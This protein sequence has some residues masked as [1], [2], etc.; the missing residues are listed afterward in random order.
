MPYWKSVGL[1]WKPI[2]WPSLH[3]CACFAL[4]TVRRRSSCNLVGVL[5]APPTESHDLSEVYVNAWRVGELGA[6]KLVR[7]RLRFED[8]THGEKIRIRHGRRRNFHR[9]LDT[10]QHKASQNRAASRA[11][12]G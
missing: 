9:L 12:A 3:G 4:C 6:D 2:V 10:D 1:S 7:Q 8:I 5:V 11:T